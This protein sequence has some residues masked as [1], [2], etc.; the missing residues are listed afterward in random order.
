MFLI[1]TFFSENQKHVIY[2]YWNKSSSS[3]T[4]IQTIASINSWVYTGRG[5]GRHLVGWGVVLRTLRNLTTG[6]VIRVSHKLAGRG[7]VSIGGTSG[8]DTYYSQYKR[9]KKQIVI[10][11]T[12]KLTQSRTLFN[13]LPLTI[14]AFW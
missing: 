6:G 13:I 3:Q 5:R 12:I 14:I 9:L 1:F 2:I 4:L 7:N 8:K 10:F 11:C